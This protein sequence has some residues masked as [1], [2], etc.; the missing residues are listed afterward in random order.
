MSI[1]CVF[2]YLKPDSLIKNT[3]KFWSQQTGFLIPSTFPTQVF[4]LVFISIACVSYSL[5]WRNIFCFLEPLFPPRFC[6]I[7]LPT[8]LPCNKSVLSTLHTSRKFTTHILEN[9]LYSFL[10]FAHLQISSNLNFALSSNMMLL[11][12]K[13]AI[14]FLVVKSGHFPV[15]ISPFWNYPVVNPCYRRPWWLAYS[16]STDPSYSFQIPI[17]LRY[18]DCPMTSTRLRETWTITN[19][20]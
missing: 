3:S 12:K 9:S 7:L 11:S 13:V 16:A 14:D 5:P 18:P 4:S 2:K 1:R 6:H 10:Q 19:E 15:V 20:C 17:W 8:N